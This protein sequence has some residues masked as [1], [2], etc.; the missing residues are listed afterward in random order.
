MTE[1]F[2][3]NNTGSDLRDDLTAA[4]ADGKIYWIEKDLPAIWYRVQ[5]CADG[6]LLRVRSDNINAEPEILTVNWHTSRI[7]QFAPLFFCIDDSLA[8][9]YFTPHFWSKT[10]P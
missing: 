9:P 3:T 10:P 1:D 4:K 8:Q 2:I 5:L 6:R 7:K